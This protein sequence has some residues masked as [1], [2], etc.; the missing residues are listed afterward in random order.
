MSNLVERMRAR[1][2]LQPSANVAM[3]DEGPDDDCQE[4][5][6]RIE[7]LEKAMAFLLEAASD[8]NQ[9]GATTGRQWIKLGSAIISARAILKDGE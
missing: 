8:V 2:D 1:R 4:A 3:V 9:R 5:A 6:D 7:A